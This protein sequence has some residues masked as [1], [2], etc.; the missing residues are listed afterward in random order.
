MIVFVDLSLWWFLEHPLSAE[1][2]RLFFLVIIWNI[3][4]VVM[5]LWKVIDLSF[6]AL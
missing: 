3:E 5:D 4:I 1:F 2:L 6:E